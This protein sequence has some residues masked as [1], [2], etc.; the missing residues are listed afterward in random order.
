MKNSDTINIIEDSDKAA[1]YVKVVCTVGIHGESVK[2][3]LTEICS[4]P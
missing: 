3:L 2:E 1:G 4:D